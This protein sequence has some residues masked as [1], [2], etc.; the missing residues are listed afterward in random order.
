MA[1]WVN[2]GE[3]V[4][5]WNDWPLD[6][7]A[8]SV[9]NKFDSL[10]YEDLRFE[11]ILIADHLYLTS[12]SRRYGHRISLRG[13]IYQLLYGR[14]MARRLSRQQGMRSF[15]YDFIS[16]SQKFTDIERLA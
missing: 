5:I 13:M 4:K 8:Q 14:K 3:D 6:H 9:C 12:E 16:L 2:G 1:E 15:Q 10:S 11:L 7:I